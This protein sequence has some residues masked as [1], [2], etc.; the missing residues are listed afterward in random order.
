MIARS[1][2]GGTRLWLALSLGTQASLALLIG[3]HDES[4]GPTS[5]DPPASVPSLTQAP[6][7]STLYLH[8]SGGTANPPVLYLDGNAPT[9]ATVK[10]K[11]SPGVAFN[12][13]N[14]WA[15]VGTWTAAPSEVN[16]SLTA[17]G[18][19]DVWLGLKNSDDVGTRFDLRVEAYRNGDLVGSGESR[20]IQGLVRNANQ[21]TEV[22]VGFDP[23]APA[24]FDGTSDVF[25]L[26]VLARIGT[27]SAGAFCG[28]HSNAT[29]LRLYFDASSR[30][31]SIGLTLGPISVEFASVS[32][33]A[34][35]TCAVTTTGVAYC[36]GSDDRG[37]LGDG[38]TT[39]PHNVPT[40][41][42]GGF[43]FASVSAGYNHTC[44]VTTAGAAYCWGNNDVGGLGN[45]SYTDSDVP[46]EVSGGLT[47]V[48]V[49]TGLSYSC[50]LTT[51]GAAYCWGFNGAGAL[52][53]G[54]GFSGNSNIP[55]A[56]AGGHTFASLTTGFSHS[57]GVTAIGDAYCWGNNDYGDLGDGTTSHR[58]IP[59]LVLG[60]PYASVLAGHFHSC[61]L[62]TAGAAFCWGFNGFGQLGNGTTT[63]NSTPNP[64]PVPVLGGITFVLATVGL[65]HSC[66]VATDAVAYCWEAT[67][68]ASWATVPT[69]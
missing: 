64:V 19:A 18:P 61:G 24:T 66:G 27:T 25:S 67:T 46:V 54:S 36:W 53:S 13:G 11:D 6:S 12:G 59:S 49:G 15:A 29:G 58:N 14:P 62:T 4:T 68:T 10:Y 39:T 2:N 55:V 35:H 65:D 47:F 37:Q 69:P 31:A 23:F 26:K 9:A 45:G 33:G 60:G 34:A 32:G 16:G 1:R 57:C 56:V 41:V 22:T 21:A 43:I 44:G 63:D 20:C 42:A 50:G 17:A 3:C 48:S 40:A 7:S 5:T 52:G 28:G 30:A 8:G 38:T 51:G